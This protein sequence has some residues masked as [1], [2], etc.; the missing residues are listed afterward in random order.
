MPIKRSAQ[1]KPTDRSRKVTDDQVARVDR[2]RRDERWSGVGSY[3]NFWQ[4]RK[5]AISAG[6]TVR[7]PARPRA[8][9]RIHEKDEGVLPQNSETW[10]TVDPARVEGRIRRGVQER[11]EDRFG[12]AWA[13]EKKVKDR[14]HRDPKGRR[15]KVRQKRRRRRI[16]LSGKCGGCNAPSP[17]TPRPP[18]PTYGGGVTPP[19]TVPPGTPSVPNNPG[20]TAPSPTPPSSPRRPPAPT[21]P[22][23]ES[24]IGYFVSIGEMGYYQ[25]EPKI[26]ELP[27]VDITFEGEEEGY[28]SLGPGEAWV[29]K[30][31]EGSVIRGVNLDVN[32]RHKLSFASNGGF[33]S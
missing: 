18:R 30:W 7:E 19:G 1:I 6:Q 8:Q 10:A 25:E 21:I 23:F 4:R 20:S 27:T 12:N 24:R 22:T 29:S 14:G 13:R 9:K 26:Y 5:E 3:T 28:L 31:Y 15:P 17:V 2:D 33:E 16:K 32:G 11:L